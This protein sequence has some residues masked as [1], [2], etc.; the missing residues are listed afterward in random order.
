MEK[1]GSGIQ[2]V[3]DPRSDFFSIPDTGSEF[4]YPGSASKNLNILTQMSKI[5]EI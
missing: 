4:L 2:D 3:F 1:G 5:L